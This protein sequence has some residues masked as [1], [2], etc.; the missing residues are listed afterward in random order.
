MTII[1]GATKFWD[2]LA[3]VTQERYARAGIT[4]ELHN[5]KVIPRKH[6]K[7]VKER[8]R[9]KDTDWYPGKP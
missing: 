1:Y 5:A 4:R 6:I 8:C 3:L 2:E 7:V 9:S